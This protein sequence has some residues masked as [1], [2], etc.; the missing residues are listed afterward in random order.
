VVSL[1]NSLQ[2]QSIKCREFKSLSIVFPRHTPRRWP[3]MIVR[4]ALAA[5]LHHQEHRPSAIGSYDLPLN[6]YI[7]RP[8]CSRVTTIERVSTLR[9]TGAL[10]GFLGLS[11]DT[12]GQTVEMLI[13]ESVAKIVMRRGNGRATNILHGSQILCHTPQTRK[14]P[15]ASASPANA[16]SE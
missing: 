13:N 8:P 14:V 2:L 16:Y 6:D 5:Q 4:I 12:C 11:K 3:V 9:R 7:P 1:T 10:S 15:M